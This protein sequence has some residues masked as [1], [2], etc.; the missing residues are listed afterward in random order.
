MIPIHELLNRIRWD[1]EFAR[2]TFELGYYDRIEHRVILVSFKEVSF[3]TDDPHALRL[4]DAEGRIHRVPL[5]RVREVYKEAQLIWQRP[6][7]E[8]GPSY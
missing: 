6:N 4:V 7:K 8:V 2:G 1:P 5:H 3:L